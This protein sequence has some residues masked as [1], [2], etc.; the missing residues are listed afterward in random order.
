MQKQPDF[1]TRIA[2]RRPD[3]LL[4]GCLDDLHEVRPVIRLR[5]MVCIEN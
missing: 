3:A 2:Q 5:I 4:F 1:E